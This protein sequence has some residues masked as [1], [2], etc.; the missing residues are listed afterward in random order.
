[1]K[2]EEQRMKSA[3]CKK[4]TR[5]RR[6]LHSQFFILHS[7]FFISCVFS[8]SLS[9]CGSIPLH[10]QDK[11]TTPAAALG[12]V[13]AAIE[14]GDVKALS[15]HT[16]GEAGATLRKPAEPHAKARQ[17]SER[18]DRALKDKPE[19]GFKNPFTVGL[20]PL[21][22]LQ[23]DV[24]E[25][26]K[27]DKK[28]PA[29]VRFGPRSRAQEEAV[30]VHNEA[31]A[32]RVDLPGDLAKTLKSLVDAERVDR[33]AR[34]LDKLAELLDTLAKEIQE[35]GLKTKDAVVLRMLALVDDAGLADLLK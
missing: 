8:L 16:A 1:M 15:A 30:F 31:G 34:G 3:E 18:L 27:E 10:A 23:Y 35:G 5:A 12:F 19:I 2:N 33:Q 7:S 14:S 32:W 21:A 6:S 20:A 17:A 4:M 29:R 13:K 9:L 25:V 11:A 24:V 26:G 28:T 22:D